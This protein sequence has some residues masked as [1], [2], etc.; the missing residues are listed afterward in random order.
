[1]TNFNYVNHLQVK[2][3]PGD[4]QDHGDAIH[5]ATKLIIW[6]TAFQK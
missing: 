1:M 4:C 6:V 3:T 2:Q 5:C